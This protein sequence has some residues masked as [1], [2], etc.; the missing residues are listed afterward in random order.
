MDNIH[1]GCDATY[2]KTERRLRKKGHRTLSQ[3][4]GP[5]HRK[6]QT[7]LL[8]TRCLHITPKAELVPHGDGGSHSCCL[9]ETQSQPR[10][11][12]DHPPCHLPGVH[13]VTWPKFHLEVTWN[14]GFTALSWWRQLDSKRK[15]L[16][17]FHCGCECRLNLHH[18]ID[19]M[20]VH[21]HA[22]TNQQA[23]QID[24]SIFYIKYMCMN[25]SSYLKHYKNYTKAFVVEI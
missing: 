16:P 7:L 19:N 9:R 1:S 10:P 24:N 8:W 18:H 21:Y 13:P 2:I 5:T 4:R 17:F 20:Y 11:G 6:T 15:L 22:D 12:L 25:N 23:I 14:H 3:L